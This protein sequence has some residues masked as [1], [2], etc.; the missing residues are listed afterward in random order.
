[1]RVALGAALPGELAHGAVKHVG[2]EKVA[3]AVED[4]GV[5][6]VQPAEGVARR[7]AAGDS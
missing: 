7:G 2:H 3:A 1:M 5:G 4:Q 6:I